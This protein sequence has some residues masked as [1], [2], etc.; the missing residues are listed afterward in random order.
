MTLGAHDSF[1]T[2]RVCVPVSA[3]N[4]DELERLTSVASKFGDLVE[5]RLDYLHPDELTIAQQQL[6]GLV[7]RLKVPVILTF[8]PSEEGGQRDLS[9]EQRK[10][11]WRDLKKPPSAFF[12]IERDLCEQLAADDPGRIICSHHDFSGVPENLDEL[13][14]ELSSTS[15][16]I[17]KIAVHAKDAVDCLPLFHLLNRASSEGRELIALAMGDAGLATRVLGP[18][19]GSFLTYASFE[20]GAETAPGQPTVERMKSVYRVDKITKHTAVYGLVGS[21]VLHSISPHVHNTAF[22]TKRIDAVYLPF[23]VK[24][25]DAFM[26]RMVHPR[27]RELD[28]QLKGLSVTAPH[29]LEIMKYLDWIDPRA[30][31]VGAVNTVV[32]DGERLCGYNTDVDGFV[33]PLSKSVELTSTTK[34]ALIGAGGAANAAIW[35]LKQKNAD[36][37]V[38]ARDPQKARTLAERFEVTCRSLESASFA[39]FDVVLNAT[40]LGS[41]GSRADETPATA[42]QLRGAF[43][44]Y[45]LVYNPIETRFLREARSA[46]CQTLGGLEMLVAQAQLQFKLWTG[47]EAPASIMHAAAIHALAGQ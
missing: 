4:Y 41:F 32:V 15:A 27:S 12:D 8:R 43:L 23:E 9:L 1:N 33:E 26:K 21:P 34:V 22:E 18:S 30:V 6:H 17:L 47:Q 11:F 24:D 14:R 20:Q 38:F 36:V 29:K 31:A 35:A 45:D 10:S 40:P 44:A 28:W 46:G 25:L 37:V 42:E 3:S 13:Y 39:G 19:R 2:A 16:R 7:E 5:L